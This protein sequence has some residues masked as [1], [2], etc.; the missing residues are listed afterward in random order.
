MMMNGWKLDIGCGAYKEEGFI[1]LDLKPHPTVD[2]IADCMSLP[3]RDKCVD[4]LYVLSL[5]EHFENPYILLE[6]VCR[7]IKSDCICDFIVPNVGTYSSDS[8][9]TH[10]FLTD[11]AHWHLIFASFFERITILPFGVRFQSSSKKWIM[12]QIELIE[13][14]LWDL[15]Q[16][17]TFRCSNLKSDI[18]Y[19]Y[20]PH[21][22]EDYARENGRHY[23]T[24]RKAANLPRLHID[25]SKYDNIKK[26]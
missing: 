2:I 8:D 14:G 19:N 13:D 10:K 24:P 25:L 22:M 6:K 20:V 1:G 3:F 5:I 7:I 21:Y 12:Q 16:G 18:V 23:L 9:P 17:F 11:M 4:Q 26:N 15:A